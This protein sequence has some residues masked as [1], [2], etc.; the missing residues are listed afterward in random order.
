MMTIVKFQILHR[1]TFLSRVTDYDKLHEVERD[2]LDIAAEKYIKETEQ[3]LGIDL[4]KIDSENDYLKR[5]T[6]IELEYTCDSDVLKETRR[7]KVIPS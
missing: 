2:G 4:K 3:S 1:G 5:C 6:F 7:V